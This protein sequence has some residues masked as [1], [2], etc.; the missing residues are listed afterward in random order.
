MGLMETLAWIA[1][2]DNRAALAARWHSLDRPDLDACWMGAAWSM[3][4]EDVRAQGGSLRA[5]ERE[6]IDKCASGAITGKGRGVGGFHDI[7]ANDWLGGKL[8]QGNLPDTLL[9][10]PVSGGGWSHVQFRRDDVLALWP[11]RQTHESA[12]PKLK[13]RPGPSPDLGW[14]DKVYQYCKAVGPRVVGNSNTGARVFHA[15]VK[16]YYRLGRDD[17]PKSE[18]RTQ[19][20]RQ[21]WLDEQAGLD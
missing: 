9:S 1:L 8:F 10:D 18:K 19:H 15:E 21:R 11:E 6:A 12:A 17:K 5:V 20:W 2:R 4:A 13:A 3:L 14:K 16:A 7:P